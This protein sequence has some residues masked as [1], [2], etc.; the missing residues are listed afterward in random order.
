MCKTSLVTFEMSRLEST[1]QEKSFLLNTANA[2]ATG[3]IEE[4]I[5]SQ[6][7]GTNK[8]LTIGV[9]QSSTALGV[10]QWVVYQTYDNTG[11]RSFDGQ[12]LTTTGIVI[13]CPANSNGTIVLSFFTVQ[14]A[15][16]ISHFI[17]W[18]RVTSTRTQIH[19]TRV[20]NQNE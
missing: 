4:V 13:E 3:T 5:F 12:A 9:R 18:N 19:V 15:R 17:R 20:F 14:D 11:K 16:T 10:P 7:Q 2:S 6:P 1:I 8:D